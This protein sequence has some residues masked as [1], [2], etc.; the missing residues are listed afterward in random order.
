ML[1]SKLHFHRHIDYLHSQALK[2]LGLI[3]LITNHFLL[4]TVENSFKAWVRVCRLNNLT[5]VDANKLENIRK[6]LQIYAI[7]DLL[8]PPSF[9]IMNQCWIIYI[10]KW[11]IWDDKI[12]TL[13]FF[14][15]FSRI[16]LTVV[17]LR[18]LLI[19]IYPLSILETF[20]LSTSVMSQDLALEQGASRLQTTS[21]NLWTFSINI[22]SPLRIYFPLFNPTELNH[23]RVACIISLPSIKF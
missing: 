12:L 6:S 2:L 8:S 22:T 10:L 7:I 17:L 20:P 5:V 18:M 3:R 14:V 11:F 23:Y 13:Y 1:Y 16:K 15:A 19:S 4:W 21:A 9:V